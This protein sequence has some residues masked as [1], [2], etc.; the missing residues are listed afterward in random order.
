MPHAHRAVQVG[1]AWLA[2]ASFLMIVVFGLHGPSL[3][4]VSGLILLTSQSWDPLESVD[5]SFAHHSP[6]A[7]RAVNFSTARLVPPLHRDGPS[8][9]METHE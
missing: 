8:S 7:A 4:A 3:Y 1:G 2:A 6:A 5:Q 9:I